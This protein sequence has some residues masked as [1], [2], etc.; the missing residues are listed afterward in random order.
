M[1]AELRVAT[2]PL[3]DGLIVLDAF[4]LGGEAGST[5]VERLAAALRRRASANT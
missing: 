2:S 5:S 3:A 4:C 1:N